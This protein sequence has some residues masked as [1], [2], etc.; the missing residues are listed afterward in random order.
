MRPWLVVHVAIEEILQRL[1][2]RL[3][4]RGKLIKLFR[5]CSLLSL[6]SNDVVANRES[7][8]QWDA[9][10]QLGW[11]KRKIDLDSVYLFHQLPFGVTQYRV[12]L[13]FCLTRLISSSAAL[14]ID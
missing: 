14:R 4:E 9:A 13:G 3:R 6:A 11:K 5:C 7:A 2:L 12:R 1:P 10:L 8:D